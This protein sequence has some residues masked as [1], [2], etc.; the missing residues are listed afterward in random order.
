MT[1]NFSLASVNWSNKPSLLATE[2]TAGS[3]AVSAMD[4]IQTPLTTVNID[5]SVGS[6]RVISSELNIGSKYS[7][8]ACT[9][10]QLSMM[11]CNE[12]KVCSHASTRERKGLT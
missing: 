4:S 2:R 1:S 10:S 3:R 11:S 8:A 12:V 7:H 5:D 9:L 6:W